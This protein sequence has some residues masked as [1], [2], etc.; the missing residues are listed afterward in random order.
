MVN[1]A[2]PDHWSRGCES[3]TLH[4]HSNTLAFLH[5]ESQ[6]KSEE[7]SVRQRPGTGHKPALTG[8]VWS[9]QYHSQGLSRQAST[10][11]RVCLVKPVALT[12]SVSSS[13]Y[14]LQG[15]SRQASTT[16]RVCLVKPVPLKTTG[17][18]W[19]SQYHLRLQ[20]L[21]GRASTT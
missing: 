2:A 20:G 16:Y 9:S 14:H 8:S 13:Q 12:G 7:V 17:S 10:I 5:T 21:S 19:L 1:L 6:R 11:H 15:L 3:A 4:H 18:V